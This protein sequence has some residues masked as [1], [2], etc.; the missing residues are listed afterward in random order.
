MQ[1]PTLVSSTTLGL[2]ALV[3]FVSLTG[4]GSCGHR[5]PPGGGDPAKQA[6]FVTERLN[7]ALDD[8]DATPAQRTQ[9]GAIKDRLLADA[10]KL[11]GARK[12]TH[13]AMLAEW[14]AEKVDR[15][16]VHALIDQRAEEMKA[17]AH[18]AADAAIE[19][20]DA[21]TPEQRAKLAKK[22]ERMHG[23]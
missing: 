6:A 3:A 17:L 5:G 11:Q 18:Q 1:K 23:R 13:E 9:L 2:L 8:I 7:D 4:F 22:A 12:A 14:N 10:Q 20:H 21:L 19:A 16:K 15:V